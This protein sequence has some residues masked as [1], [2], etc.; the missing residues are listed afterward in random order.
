VLSHTYVPG[1]HVLDPQISTDVDD[2]KSG[3]PDFRINYYALTTP[4]MPKVSLPHDRELQQ[5]IALD[6]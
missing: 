6:K 3:L 5:Q 1:I 4:A 2:R